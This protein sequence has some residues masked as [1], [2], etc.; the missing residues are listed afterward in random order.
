MAAFKEGKV[1]EVTSQDE[2][3][4]RARVSVAGGEVAAIGYPPHVARLSVGDRVVLNVTGIELELGTGGTGFILWNLDAPPPDDDLD[5]HIVKL[6]YTPWQVNVTSVEAQ[7]S[8]HHELMVAAGSLKGT[9]V[10]ACSLHSQV[11]AAAAGIRAARPDARIGYLMTDGAALPLAFSD[12]VR[13]M[14]EARLIDIT[15][16]AGHAF[17]GDLEAV[18]VFS[19][20]AALATVAGCDAIVA[21]MG[22]GVVGTGTALGFTGMEQGQITDATI[23]LGGVAVAAL[24]ISFHD[25]RERH[26]GVSHHSI[27]ALSVAARERCVVAVPKLRPAEARAVKEQLDGSD[28]C[29]KHDVV[30]ADG[31]PGVRWLLDHDLVPTSMGRS[32]TDAPELWLAA[33]AAGAIAT[34]PPEGHG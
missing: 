10:V 25:E 15:C 7:E 17:G 22:P 12:L 11:P 3:L 27:T 18:N 30:V 4:V 13:A 1:L 34:Q 33:A 24:R 21:A 32:M 26:K 29:R 23:A 2:R 9:P 19:G 16:T 31:R 8:G 14:T 6:R 28:V 5:G 20:L